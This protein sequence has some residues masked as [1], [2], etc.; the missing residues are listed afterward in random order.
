[1]PENARIML[2]IFGEYEWNRP[3]ITGEVETYHMKAYDI[4]NIT[5]LQASENPTIL[6]CHGN[7]KTEHNGDREG[8]LTIHPNVAG[9][10]INTWE[11]GSAENSKWYVRPAPSRPVITASQLIQFPTRSTSPQEQSAEQFMKAF[12]ASESGNGG[13]VSNL[14][15]FYGDNVNFFGGIIPRSKVMIEKKKFA[16]RWTARQYAPSITSIECNTV[17]TVSG[18]VKWDVNSQE[19]NSRSI[20]TASFVY[21][22]SQN[23]Q[24]I[25]ENG[26][27]IDRTILP[28][29]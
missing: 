19:R 26:A 1:M 13:D 21:V 6:S 18:I 10:T 14:I 5:T 27:V 12:Y 7:W 17:C 16:D 24:L 28:M 22:I 15:S 23:G 8:T 25:S 29:R 11:P 9:D 3:L 4:D 20:G 2:D